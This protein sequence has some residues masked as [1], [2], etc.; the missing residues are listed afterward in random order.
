MAVAPH[1]ALVGGGC[2]VGSPELGE[3]E[4]APL[5]IKFEHFLGFSKVG[6]RGLGVGA[7]HVELP[8]S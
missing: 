1:Q 2:V 7:A 4:A 5:V 6:Q 8:F 3:S